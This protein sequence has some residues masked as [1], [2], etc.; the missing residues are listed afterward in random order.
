MAKFPVEY[1]GQDSESIVDAVNYV[2]S[3]PSG[4]GQNSAGFNASAPAYLT[5]NFR[6]P[7]TRP[8]V[9]TFGSGTAGGNTQTVQDPTGIVNGLYVEG[10]NITS[11]G[12]VINVNY[13]LVTNSGYNNAGPVSGQINYYQ[14]VPDNLYVAPISLASAQWIDEYTRRFTFSSAQPTPPF[15]PGNS[16][17]TAGVSPV[18][19]NETFR[20]PGV[21]ECTTTSVVV[22]SLVP[23]TALAAGTGGTVTYRNTLQIGEESVNTFVATDCASRATVTGGTDRVFVTAQLDNTISY[24]A[25]ATTDLAYTVFVNRYQSLVTNDLVNPGL[26]FSFDRTITQKTSHALGLTGSGTLLYDTNFSTVID[27]PGNGY[28]LYRIDVQ[29]RVTNA[30]GAAQVTRSLLDLRGLTTQVVKQ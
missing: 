18:G 8:P 15:L 9:S 3:G 30:T 17:T 4:A 1:N 29:F 27:S 2:L 23:K 5:G 20:G 13:D 19:Y 16:V 6:Q 7:Y 12:T 14:T 10:Y 24:T 26:L 21:V 11:G 25:T 22:K 28:Y